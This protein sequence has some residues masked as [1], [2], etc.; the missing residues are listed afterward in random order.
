MYVYL[1]LDACLKNFKFNLNSKT[2]NLSLKNNSICALF[3]ESIKIVEFK[4]SSSDLKFEIEFRNWNFLEIILKKNFKNDE[5]NVCLDTDC[6]ATL[7]DKKFIFT[8]IND[9]RI[10]KMITLFQI[11]E[12]DF[13]IYETDE[14][15][16]ILIYFL[17]KNKNEQSTLACIIQKIYLIDN[18]KVNMLID[19]DIIKFEN[20]VIDISK[21]TAII[22]SCEIITNLFIKQRKL[23]VKTNILSNHRIIM[24]FDTQARIS[25]DYNISKERNF[26][27]QFFI[28]SSCMMFYHLINLY[29]SEIIMRN[30]LLQFVIISKKFCL[31]FV[32]KLTYN[33]CF[34]IIEIDMTMQ[35]SK[36]KW[37]D[38][39][40]YA[41]KTIV[42]EIV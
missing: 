20:F 29:I 21:R 12:M 23:F 42:E 13:I 15:V 6:N 22:E 9:L 7:C 17:E 27:F 11:R 33:H 25:F 14:F 36:K 4:I 18:F 35:F 34:Q 3:I 1:R 8:K 37:L 2:Q 5:T 40:R 16:M 32:S 41:I 26:L 31:K 10:Q 28:E 38:M 39:N 30:N 24:T 19:N